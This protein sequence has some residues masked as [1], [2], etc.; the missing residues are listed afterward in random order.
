MAIETT[1]L[2]VALADVQAAAGRLKGVINQ[3]PLQVSR[4]LGALTGNEVYLKPES[5]Q[6]TGSFKIRGAYNR[7]AT[8]SDAER[9]RGVITYS[10]G[11]HAQGTACAAS[12]LG[13][14][15]VV[16]MPEDAVP[17]KAAATRGYGA[18]V[19]FCGT[20]SLQ[21]QQRAM[22]L[23]AERG[24]TV[25]PPFDD[26]MIIAGQGTAGL[27]ILAEQPDVE[28]VLVPV[29]GGGLVSGVALAIKESNPQVRVIGVEP[30]GGADARESLRRG[31]IYTAPTI[32]TIAD[33]LRTKRIGTLNFG[34]MR[35]Y[36]DDIVVV[37][38]AEIMRA[39]HLLLTRAKLLVEPSGSV[40]VAALMADRAGL[41]GQ[42]VVCVLSGGNADVELV[43][44][45]LAAGD[46]G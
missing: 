27:E 26:P 35:R 32:D 16:V 7:I 12:L 10:S 15:A 21:R 37:S 13:V 5:L 36:L 28:T 20:D 14:E 3:T 34:V 46:G 43:G 18:E 6:R 23:V 1:G 45:V 4:T 11:N 2:G 38:D 33:G 44:R 24:Y 8:L 40:A 30:A 17:A 41:K 42:R 22:E 39:M 9:A 25:V 19:V 31:E 29:G